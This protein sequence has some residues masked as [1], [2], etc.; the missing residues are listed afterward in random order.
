MSLFKTDQ[1][2]TRNSYYVATAPRLQRHAALQDDVTADVA[3]VGGG[4]AGLS[5]ALELAQ[6]GYSVVLLEAREVGW[7]ASGRNGGQVIAGLA[8]DISVIEEQLGASAARR[9]WDMTVE[10]VNLVHER[11]ARHDIDCE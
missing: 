6:R 11:R 1:A 10:A 9:V 8:S 5:A 7:G 2:L 4:L 3:V